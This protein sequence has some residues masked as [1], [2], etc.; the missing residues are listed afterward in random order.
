MQS[1]IYT[2][3]SHNCTKWPKNNNVSNKQNDLFTFS[4]PITKN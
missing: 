2:I 4:L 3:E 1:R